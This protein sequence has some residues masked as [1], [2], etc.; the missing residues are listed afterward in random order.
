MK[1]CPDCG[2]VLVRDTSTG[3]IEFECTTCA[4]RIDGDAWDARISGGVLHSGETAE[5]YINLIRNA[6]DDRVD[7][8]VRRDCPKCG[9]DYMTQVRVGDRE[10]VIH[11]CKCGHE[12]GGSTD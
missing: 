9:L 8:L 1:F 3:R 2:R 6:A 4:N 5:K 10:V 12:E 11:K 7:Q